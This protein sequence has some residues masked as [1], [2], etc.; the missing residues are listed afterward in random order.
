MNAQSISRLAFDKK[1]LKCASV[2]SMPKMERTKIFYN[3]LGN[4]KRKGKYIQGKGGKANEGV[5]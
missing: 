4:K 1:C 3:F 2:A 5:F